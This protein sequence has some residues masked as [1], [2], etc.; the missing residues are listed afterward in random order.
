MNEFVQVPFIRTAGTCSLVRTPGLVRT[1][2]DEELARMLADPHLTRVCKRADENELMNTSWLFRFD[3]PVGWTNTY[4]NKL[5]YT[6]LTLSLYMWIY[7]YSIYKYQYSPT[8]FHRGRAGIICA[9]SQHRIGLSICPTGVRA[10]TTA[11]SQRAWHRSVW[12]NLCWTPCVRKRQLNS[13]LGKWA[14]AALTRPSCPSDQMLL[15]NPIPPRSSN[16][17]HGF[18]ISKKLFVQRV[19]FALLGWHRWDNFRY[20]HTYRI[21]HRIT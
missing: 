3:W 14:G 19:P 1:R 15:P 12:A 2:D 9:K 11:R 13:N 16:G 8:H 7:E 10:A 21:W 17:T 5:I 6:H 20:A 18:H 4:R